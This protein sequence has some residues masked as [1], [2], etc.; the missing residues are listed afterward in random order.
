MWDTILPK[1]AGD[2][3]LVTFNGTVRQADYVEYPKG[4]FYWSILP[5]GSATSGVTAWQRQPSPY[6]ND[7]I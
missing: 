6:K 2:R 5:S 4:N 3:Y 1:K 7:E